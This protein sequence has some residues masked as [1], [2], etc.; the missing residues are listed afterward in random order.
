MSQV[1]LFKMAKFHDVFPFCL[2]LFPRALVNLKD[3]QSNPLGSLGPGGCDLHL[4]QIHPKGW[5]EDPPDSV[6]RSV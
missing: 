4:W 5:K 2:C 3:D 1:E 6:Q